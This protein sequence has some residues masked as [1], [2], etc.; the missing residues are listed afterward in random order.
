MNVNEY[1]KTNVDEW[2]ICQT[3][4]PEKVLYLLIIFANSLPTLLYNVTT[5]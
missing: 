5:E 1:R 2:W 3:S 4:S